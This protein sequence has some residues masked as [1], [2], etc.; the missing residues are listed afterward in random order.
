MNEEVH[1]VHTAFLF[2]AVTHVVNLLV[3]VNCFEPHTVSFQVLAVRLKEVTKSQHAHQVMLM[4]D[5][6]E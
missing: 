1:E 2:F 6:V 5:H 4:H 3:T